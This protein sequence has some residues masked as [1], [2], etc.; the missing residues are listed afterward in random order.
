MFEL[1]FFEFSKFLDDTSEIGIQIGDKKY[2]IGKEIEYD[3]FANLKISGYVIGD[4]E[5]KSK[6]EFLKFLDNNGIKDTVTV[7]RLDGFTDYEEYKKN[8]AFMNADMKYLLD[9][10]KDCNKFEL[11]GQVMDCYRITADESDEIFEEHK[12]IDRMNLKLLYYKFLSKLE[13]EPYDD[14][15]VNIKDECKAFAGKYKEKYLKEEGFFDNG[16]I[17]DHLGKDT[18]YSEPRDLYWHFYHT[19]GNEIDDAELLTRMER[20][21]EPFYPKAIFDKDEYKDLLED[22]IDYKLS[23]HSHCTAASSVQIIYRFKLTDNSKA[24][25]LKH[26]DDYDFNG[27]LQD[28]AFYKDEKLRFSSCT[29]EHY[30]DNI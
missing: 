20:K 8:K 30:H 28:L 16:F 25:L 29:H 19:L 24:W 23:F 2:L 27:E 10:Y 15:Y 13:L 1:S 3:N 11:V 6:V 7:V 18:R 14:I 4:Q 22:F 26:K 21:G 5:F 9:M 12:N 17:A